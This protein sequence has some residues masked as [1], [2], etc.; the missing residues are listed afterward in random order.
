MTAMSTIHLA[1]EGEKNNF[2]VPNA[3][4]MVEV[5]IVA[6]VLFIIW[7]YVVPPVREAMRERR[8]MV[9]RQLDESRRA[10]EKF[11]AAE[12]RHREAL[13]EARAEAG[14][15]RDSARADGQRI[16]DELREQA[17]TEVAEVRR[18]GAEQLAA[19]REQV[20]SEL[21]P[22]VRELAVALASRVV[23]E[24]VGAGRRKR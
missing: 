9:Q 3:T 10:D 17:N 12:E 14:K 19:Q 4:I 22:H 20:L 18:Q 8:E 7:R 5:I 1:Q 6:V 21:E 24:N 2:L 11:A 15:I 16:I 23:G 13:N